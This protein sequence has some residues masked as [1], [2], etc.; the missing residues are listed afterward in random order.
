MQI[1]VV[2][3]G[4]SAAEA[5][6]LR[7]SLATFKRMGT[8]GAFRERFISGMLSRGYEADFAERCFARIE[9]FGSYRPVSQ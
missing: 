3:A 7:R 6:R 8:I 9:G 1:A 5:D 2:A 4:F